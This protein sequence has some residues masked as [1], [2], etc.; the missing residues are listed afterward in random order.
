MQPDYSVAAISS[1][2]RNAQTVF[3]TFCEEIGKCNVDDV[4]CFV[5]GF[6]EPY[7]RPRITTFSNGHE[8]RFVKG[9]GK[10]IVI[11]FYELIQ[12]KPEYDKYK[13]MF[14]V[15]SDYDDNSNLNPNIYRTPCY[16]IE[17]FYINKSVIEGFANN[18]IQLDDQNFD[19]VKAQNDADIKFK[20]LNF[21]SLK[22]E[23]WL[24]AVSPFC[25]WYKCVKNDPNGCNVNLDD[26]F[27]SAYVEIQSDK[28]SFVINNKGYS[29]SNMNAEYC[30]SVSQ[31][32][33]D[34]ALEYIHTNKDYYVRGKYVLQFIERLLS[35][36][37]DN[38]KQ[39]KSKR[40]YS[41]KEIN[42]NVNKKRLMS[43]LSPYAQST[44]CLTT[45]A[46]NRMQEYSES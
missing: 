28:E 32:E 43:D 20:M 25:A 38:S 18:V 30:T 40:T 35:F 17:N 22:K 41:L 8:V 36:W 31:T 1:A 27:P 12:K 16:S 6:D 13:K 2:G 9:Y 15:D 34:K 46:Q 23:E 39:P 21:F 5:E 14:F 45:Y 19:K 4:F 24:N 11:D 10:R 29:L 44:S 3:M 37:V 42:Y 26:V 7:Y 33:F